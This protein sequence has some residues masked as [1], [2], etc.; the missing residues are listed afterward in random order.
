MIPKTYKMSRHTKKGK[1]EVSDNKENTLSLDDISRLLDTKLEP[2][3]K[4]IDDFIRELNDVKTELNA[5]TTS[6]SHMDATVQEHDQ[7][8]D[9]MDREMKA[10][11]TDLTEHEQKMKMLTEKVIQNETQSRRNNLRLC[12]VG[13]TPQPED[14]EKLFKEN[15]NYPR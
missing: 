13:E 9:K 10:L 5:A 12:G 3:T 1:E 14:S 15:G 11:E 6:L 8:I 4:K 2:I 7:K